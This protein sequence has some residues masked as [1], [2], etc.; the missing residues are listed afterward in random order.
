MSRGTGPVVRSVSSDSVPSTMWASLTQICPHAQLVSIGGEDGAVG[1]T[2]LR[3]FAGPWDSVG[4]SV[5]AVAGE[6]TART[7]VSA[8]VLMLINGRP[9]RFLFGN[10][11]VVASN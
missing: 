9:I 3:T 6:E 7:S 10:S 11:A 1:Y 5:T 8:L 4:G 2:R